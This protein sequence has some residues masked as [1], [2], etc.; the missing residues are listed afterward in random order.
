MKTRRNVLLGLGLALAASTAP[1][2]AQ[3]AFPARQITLIVPFG[4]GGPTDVVARLVAKHMEGTLGKPVVVENVGG[5]GGTTGMT[6]VA[7]AAPDGYTIGIGNAGT[8]S[9]APALYA[10]LKY[11]P[12]T[13]FDQIG[14]L[15]HTPM[16]IVGKTAL[17]AKTLAEAVT[18]FKANESKLTQ[19]HAG[20]GST[21]HVAGLVLNIQIGVKPALVA[22]RGTAPAMNDLVAGQFDFMVDQALNIIP[23]AKAGTIKAFAVAAPARL[24]S[25]PDVPT[26][27]EAGVD[28][29]FSGWNAMVAP[30]G[31]PADVRT[32]LV[33]AMNKALDD[34]SFKTRMVELGSTIPQGA[35]RGPAGLQRIVESEVAR[36][37]PILKAAGAVGN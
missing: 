25:L 18:G 32:K 15:N 21:S 36:L 16:V 22:Y 4:A 3:D 23:Q 28:F 2:F 31:L 26:T 29:L 34:A 5:A 1:A 10:N 6:R 24:E 30:K 14:I 19:G 8:Q 35:E 17:P 9:A 27:K 20:V 7:Q 11:D 37:T 13:S 33:D 12:A